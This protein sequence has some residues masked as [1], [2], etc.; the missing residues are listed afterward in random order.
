MKLPTRMRKLAERA[1]ARK[2]KAPPTRVKVS[3]RAATAPA[4]PTLVARA[5]SCCWGGVGQLGV[6]L[7]PRCCFRAGLPAVGSWGSCASLA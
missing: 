3:T 6:L 4:V 1:S 7:C 5:G 2:A